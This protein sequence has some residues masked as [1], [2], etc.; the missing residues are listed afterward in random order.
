M[1]SLKTMDKRL[2]VK[3]NDRNFVVT[4]ARPYGEPVNVHLVRTAD[5]GFRQPDQ[6]D[7]SF[8]KSGDLENDRLK[9]KLERIARHSE[10]I[11]EKSRKNSREE[12][13]A[14]TRDNREQLKKAVLQKANERKANSAFRRIEF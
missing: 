8:I 1:K 4:Y 12:V 5:G 6:R 2:D 11:R 9:D 10:E 14:M 3:F 13:R 7:L